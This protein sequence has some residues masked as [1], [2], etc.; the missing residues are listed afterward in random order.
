MVDPE[1]GARCTIRDTRAAGAERYH[2]TVNGV[3]EP[4][5]VAAERTSELAEARSQV[6]PALAGK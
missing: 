3:G 2:W 6:E 4:Y 5:P 1:S